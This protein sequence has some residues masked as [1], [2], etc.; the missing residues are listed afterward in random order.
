MD[1]FIGLSA[2]APAVRYALISR[3]SR[4]E[5]NS[6][7]V[8]LKRKQELSVII[9][10]QKSSDDSDGVLLKKLIELETDLNK[11]ILNLAHEK[12]ILPFLISSAAVSAVMAPVF[13]WLFRHALDE[14]IFREDLSKAV[15]FIVIALVSMTLTRLFKER[16]EKRA[17][18]LLGFTA[19]SLAVFLLIFLSLSMGVIGMD[20]LTRLF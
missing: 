7:M 8:L 14:G 11:K 4:L 20:P 18:T 13:V 10:Q 16:L 2:F 9:E 6:L 17:E 19:M 5:S 3:N 12:S 1:E 15:L